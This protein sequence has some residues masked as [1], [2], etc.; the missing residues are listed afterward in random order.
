MKCQGNSIDSYLKFDPNKLGSLKDHINNLFLAI[1]LQLVQ[2]EDVVCR[3][4]PYTFL[5]KPLLGISAYLSDQLQ[6]LTV[7]KQYL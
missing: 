5:G 2:H 7:L 1:C 6:T 4:F 3:L